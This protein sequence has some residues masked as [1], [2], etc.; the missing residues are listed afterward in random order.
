MNDRWRADFERD[1]FLVLPNFI[2]TAACE[3]LR[4]RM[5]KLVD[6]FEP[7]DVATIFSTT[8]RTHA[9]DDYFL[10]SGDKI[11]FFF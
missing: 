7:N 8:E 11:R 1:G 4:E 9:Q 3:A 10:S 2:E 5:A 6:D